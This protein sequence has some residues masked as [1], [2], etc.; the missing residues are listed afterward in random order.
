MVVS[1]GFGL[2][3][4]PQKYSVPPSSP[5]IEP[6]CSQKRLSLSAHPD[7]KQFSRNL[8]CL[9]KDIHSDKFIS[10][11]HT[12]VLDYL[13][14][15]VQEMSKERKL[16][17]PVI[18]W[19]HISRDFKFTE[20]YKGRMVTAIS[21]RRLDSNSW[22]MMM[23]LAGM[24]LGVSTGIRM[25]PDRIVLS[26][27]GRN[28][29]LRSQPDPELVE[30]RDSYYRNQHG[31]ERVGQRKALQVLQPI[32]GL[33]MLA[34]FYYRRGQDI[35]ENKCPL[36]SDP[37]TVAIDYFQ[38]AKHLYQT[39]SL[40]WFILA[41][42]KFDQGDAKSALRALHHAVSESGKPENFFFS[43][44]GKQV[45]ELASQL[46]RDIEADDFVSQHRIRNI[47]EK[48]QSP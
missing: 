3:I 45:R 48:I 18:V 38:K 27:A 11:A 41:R 42:A 39:K 23:I 8:L 6:Y 43:R 35:W 24:R 21:Q 30:R 47:F 33:Q 19:D 14:R 44:F 40:F 46:Q 9:D 26:W 12:N 36:Q 37:L 20:E 16:T 5:S 25:L 7:I 31:L 10:Q 32:Q 2:T 15:L 29:E 34:Y 13:D 22:L 17:D 4:K 28:F 1:A